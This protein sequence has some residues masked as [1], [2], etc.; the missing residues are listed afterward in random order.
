[1]VS[2]WLLA[3]LCGGRYDAAESSDVGEAATAAAGSSDLG[4]GKRSTGCS[5]SIMQIYGYLVFRRLSP[6]ASG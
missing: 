1:M 6:E 2:S 4:Q 3:D 5:Y